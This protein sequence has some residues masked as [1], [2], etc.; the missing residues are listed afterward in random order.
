[1]RIV[2]DARES[3]TSTGR[4]VDKLIEYL[5]KLSPNHSIIVIAKSERVGFIKAT[6][7]GFEV[8]ECN[9]KEFSFAEQLA[10]KKQ[11]ANLRPDLV[12]F[13]MPQQ[14][15]LYRGRTVT[16]VHDLTTAR[17]PNPAK[18]PLIFRLKQLVYRFVL[19]KAARK[20][21]RLIAISQFTK[22]D[23]ANFSRINP[24]KI[25]VI[26]EA[27]DKIEVAAEPMPELTVQ[28]FILFVGRPN[29]HKN[30][31]RLIGAMEEL[32]AKHPDLK[33]V[34]AGKLD[35]NYRALQKYAIDNNLT[36]QVY[37]TDFVSEGRLR[38]LYENALCYA[39]PSLSEGFGL[40]G[41]EAMCYSLPVAAAN[42]TCLPEIYKDAALYFDPL[43]VHD[44]AGKLDQLASDPALRKDL[45]ARG[46]RVVRSYSWAKMA[47]QTLNVY[48]EVLTPR[49]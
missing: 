33:L 13:T 27:A 2:I 34:L 31:K 35:D 44:I 3:G 23:V 47:E 39:F 22:D 36:S 26:Y 5:H 42:A 6:A 17:F 18:N 1:M 49:R 19:K 4:Y 21:A 45:A 12:H 14:P 10:L 8:V 16:T 38:W 40:P 37:F 11:I 15:I 48:E 9:I 29:P 43:D 46:D 25:E 30:L 7:P 20:S 32:G 24:E 28:K 41:L